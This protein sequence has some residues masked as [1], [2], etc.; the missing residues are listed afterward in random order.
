MK[1][2]YIRVSSLDQNEARQVEALKDMVDQIIIEKKSGKDLDRPELMKLVEFSR[3][4]DEIICKSIDR[5]ARN[6]KDLLTLVEQL[7]AKDVKVTFVDNSM[8]FDGTPMSKFVLTMMG[9]AAELERGIL[10][11]RQREGIDI[12][13]TK[14]AYK[15]KP[16]NQETREKVTKY[17]SMNAHTVEEISKLADCGIATVYRIKKELTNLQQ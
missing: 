6:T 4:G 15:G 16:K 8:T 9:A 3:S 17:L 13:K 5:L 10:R 2:A 7:N 11:Q 14:G 12:A 1:Y